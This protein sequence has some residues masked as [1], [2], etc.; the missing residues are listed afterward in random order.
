MRT[1][2]NAVVRRIRVVLKDKYPEDWEAQIRKRLEKE[3]NDIVANAEM[4]RTTGELS[5]PVEDSFSY[6]SVNHF[7]NFFEAYFDDIFPPQ[8]PV[9]AKER[10]AE[11]KT[12]LKWTKEVKNLRDPIAHPEEQPLPIDDAVRLLDTAQRICSKIDPAAAEEI[13]DLKKTLNSDLDDPTLRRGPL[14]GAL[15][16]RESTSPHFIGRQQELERLRQW[17]GDPNAR[18]WLLAGDGGKGK[19]AIAYEFASEVQQRAPRPLEIVIWM[20]AK[21]REFTERQTVDIDA[22]D[23]WDLES[24][25]NRVLTEYGWLDKVEP[26]IEA[27]KREALDLLEQLPALV[28]LDDANSLEGDQLNALSFFVLEAAKT[29]SKFLLTSRLV[30]YPGMEPMTTQI[31][32]FKP[33]EQDG[34]DFVRTRVQ[35]FNLDLAAFSAHVSDEILKVTDGS[36]LFIEDLLRLAVLGDPIARVCEDWGSRTGHPA[37]EYALGREFDRL[38]SDAHAVLLATALLNGPVSTSEITDAMHYM[39]VG[40]NLERTRDAVGELQRL[41]LVPKPRIIEDNPRFSLNQNTREL[42]LEVSRSR[43]PDLFR[44]AERAI[45]AS[46]GAVRTSKHDQITVRNF[47]RQAISLVNLGKHLEAEDTLKKG[48]AAIP[49]ASDLYAQ[50]GWVYAKW[51]PSPRVSDAR[52]NFTKAAGLKCRNRSAYYHWCQLE[53]DR[54]EW[55]RMAEAATTGLKVREEDLELLYLAG[56]AYSRMANDLFN[57]YQLSKA[58]NEAALA[59]SYL[60]RVLVDP[61]NLEYGQYQLHSQAYQSLVLTMRTV[62]RI[63]EARGESRDKEKQ[64]DALASVLERWGKEHPADEHWIRVREDSLRFYPELHDLLQH[65]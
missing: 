61:E 10:K 22:P 40:F 25:L 20:S 16:S 24:A 21:R 15:P 28:V 18:L 11:K 56:Y 30:L 58:G 37:R 55:T 27:K 64:L 53:R 23:F 32:G 60:E 34:R 57:Q 36:P 62:I 6:L 8:R 51:R 65:T 1:Y 47:T 17:V 59:Q 2:R 38:S 9:G 50:L 63:A 39:G 54:Q 3:W 26:S 29:P 48:L 44:R 13:G 45:G 7:Y 41:F 12:V 49:E 33:G 46:T 42:I 35:L 19:T 31:T 14:P 4:P 52:E 5:L 43:T